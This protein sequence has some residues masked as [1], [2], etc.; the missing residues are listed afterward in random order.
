MNNNGQLRLILGPMY[1]GKTSELLN[2]YR[3]WKLAGKKILLIKYENDTRYKEDSIVTHDGLSV[4]AYKCKLLKE[5][6]DIIVN[7]DIICV[8][9]VQFYKD[10]HIFC[11]KWAN[12]GKIV[13][14]SGLNGTYEK[15]PFEIISNL[16]PLADKI[17]HLT[18]VCTNTGNDAPF[19][20]RIVDSN[21]EI[22]IGSKD[23][24]ISGDRFTW[25]RYNLKN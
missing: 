9:E 6:D 2:R 20:I 19:S 18:A 8:D 11:D 25:N 1:S 15:K 10:G 3:R 13:E 22:L 21:E 17:D 23:M 16:V 7:Y 12:S 24:Y 4:K 5:L 14:A